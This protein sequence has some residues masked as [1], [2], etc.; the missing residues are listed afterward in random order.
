MAHAPQDWTSIS[1]ADGSDVSEFRPARLVGKQVALRPVQMEDHAMLRA[2]ELSESLGPRWRHGGATPPP[3]AWPQSHSNG[4]LAQFIVCRRT[5][6]VPLGL[7]NTYG[8]DFVNGFAYIAGYKFEPENTSPIFMLGFTLLIEYV[9]HNWDF[10]KL[11][12]ETVAYNL[13]QYQSAIGR[14]LV[15]EA[16]LSEHQY[17][18]GRYWDRYILALMR[19]R[20]EE[21]GEPLV[22]FA[23]E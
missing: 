7:V 20:W 4:V 11:Y 9:F 12:V 17:Y 3:E 1:G 2:F 13:P 8:P 18:G 21:Y 15:V 6:G 16:K 22:R 19:E 14:S 23:L 10:R 5:D